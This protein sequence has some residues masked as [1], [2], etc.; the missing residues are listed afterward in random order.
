MAS[1]GHPGPRSLVTSRR[2]A[3]ACW[4]AAR[5]LDDPPVQRAATRE[6]PLPRGSAFRLQSAPM[7][8][9]PPLSRTHLP[10]A[11]IPLLH[12]F[13]PAYG[14][15]LVP[16]SLPMRD[17]LKLWGVGAASLIVSIY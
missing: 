8:P 10:R 16:L 9:G 3:P 4:R 12:I 14:T 1:A 2:S 17:D 7:P 6:P 5:T 13:P 11:L 15:T